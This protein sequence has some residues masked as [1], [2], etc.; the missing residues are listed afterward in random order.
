M[1][2]QQGNPQYVPYGQPAYHYVPGYQQNPVYGALKP[3]QAI[4]QHHLQQTPF[5]VPVR[6]VWQSF[7]NFV[8]YFIAAFF[9]YSA[10]SLAGMYLP[11]STS[12]IVS[13]VATALIVIVV[14][15]MHRPNL[16]YLSQL[17]FG[18]PAWSRVCS[19]LLMMLWWSAVVWTGW[20]VGDTLRGNFMGPYQDIQ[21]LNT[22][23]NVEPSLYKGSQLMDAGI[24]EFVPG[25]HIDLTK[26][27]GFKSE[28]IYCVAPIVGPNTS[29]TPTYDFWAVGTNCCN[30]H[31][32]DYH[33]GEFRNAQARKG[34]RLMR[35]EQRN[36][37]RL[38]VEEAKAAYNIEAQHPVFM[39]WMESPST[40]V[41]QYQEDAYSWYFFSLQLFVPVFMCLWTLNSCTASGIFQPQW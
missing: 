11:S 15:A 36:Y 39:Y 37:F 7:C 1:M 8:F 22:Y 29:S 9:L 10:V 33:C 4:Y 30:G 40:E 35:E 14:H 41:D 3:N 31:T 21:N 5:S 19:M 32:P 27:Y 26:S 18:S 20:A 25:S 13:I 23:P 17:S 16:P 34:L 28:D 12:M 2:N 6:G 38:A 24:I